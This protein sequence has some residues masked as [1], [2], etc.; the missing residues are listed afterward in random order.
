MNNEAGVVVVVVVIIILFHL[1]PV[2]RIVY[3][4]CLLLPFGI[5]DTEV[6]IYLPIS[7]TQELS[8]REHKMKWKEHWT[9][10]CLA[11]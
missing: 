8:K 10:S 11:L 6:R 3:F 4:Q 2:A 9:E 5:N 7:L 1:V